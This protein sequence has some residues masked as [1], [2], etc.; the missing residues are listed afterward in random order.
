M[1]VK[2]VLDTLNGI[3]DVRQVLFSTT[4]EGTFISKDI[5]ELIQKLLGDYERDILA[6]DVIHR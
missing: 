1:K 4:D 2:D 3:D 6:L 5:V